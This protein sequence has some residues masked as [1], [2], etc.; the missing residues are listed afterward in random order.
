MIG[1]LHAFRPP[2]FGGS[3]EKSLASFETAFAIAGD[4]FL[5]SK[6]FF[7]RYYLYRVQEGDEFR[8]V[9]QGVIDAPEPAENPYRLLNL[10]A[11]K[12]STTLLGEADDLF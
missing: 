10:I 8:H 9:L 7:A 4:S 2:L 12:R 6:Y 11:R 1:S 5:L 3:P